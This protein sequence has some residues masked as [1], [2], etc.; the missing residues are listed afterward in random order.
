MSQVGVEH[1][2]VRDYRCEVT[3]NP[4]GTD[5]WREGSSCPCDTCQK[6]L[7]LAKNQRKGWYIEER[8]GEFLINSRAL[9]QLDKSRPLSE[10]EAEIL[11]LNLEDL[12]FEMGFDYRSIRWAIEYDQVYEKAS[13]LEVLIRVLRDLRF[14]LKHG[15]SPNIFWRW[16]HNTKPAS[17]IW[18]HPLRCGGLPCLRGTRFTIA[19]VL[20]ELA[21]GR[22]IDE[23]ADSFDLDVDM[24][25]ALLRELALNYERI[26]YVAE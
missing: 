18:T 24:L 11:R 2:Q 13:D 23:L 10:R 14:E 21:D 4:A 20:A 12:C 19:Q 26:D 22:R 8:F 16:R 6:F 9:A 7:A 15:W 25:E 3:G 5:T 1:K 17:A